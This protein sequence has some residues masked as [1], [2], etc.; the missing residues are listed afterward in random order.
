M[1]QTGR[2]VPFI[3]A[4]KAAEDKVKCR[5]GKGGRWMQWW[6][7]RDTVFWLF[8]LFSME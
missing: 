6:E 8:F 7:L 1:E 2:R 4:E 3:E 5:T